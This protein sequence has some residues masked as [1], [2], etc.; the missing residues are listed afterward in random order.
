MV[1]AVTT[2]V[3]Q[4]QVLAIAAFPTPRMDTSQ[5]G[6]LTALGAN[7]TTDVSQ[8]QVVFAALGRVYDPSVR[9]WTFTLDGHDFYVLRL[10]NQKTLVYDTA[11]GAWYVWGSGT[12]DLWRAY[13]GCNWLAGDK[14]A[15]GYGSN[16]VVGDDGNG[17]LYF[18][19][20]DQDTDDDA[21]FSG[22]KRSFE[23]IVQG[24][25]TTKGYDAVPCYAVELQG[26]VG[27]LNDALDTSIKLEISD[28]RAAT[29][30][31]CGTVSPTATS[32]R[33]SWR[34]LGSMFNPG[35][36]FK[37]TDYGALRRIDSLDTE[38]TDE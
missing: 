8:G 24:F 29:Y 14:F 19:N 18:L 33:V 10:G 27:D 31:D 2:D 22:V 34:S 35:R 7:L 9:A 15:A 32:D 17:S 12:D 1:A 36:L 28:D 13:N 11:S 6:V 30:V 26:S 25:L 4:G 38:G 23:R 37:I 3:S 16:V 20:P 5:A 21:I